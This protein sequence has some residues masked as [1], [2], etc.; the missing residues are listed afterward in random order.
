MANTVSVPD[1]NLEKLR[2]AIRCEY[3]EVA[4]APGKGFH[5]HTG[6]KLAEI[7]GY[8]DEWLA[9]IPE[10]AI[11][12]FAGTG[13][14][15]SIGRLRQGEKVLD[16]G[17]GA[18]I[19]SLI[20]ARQVGD[21]GAVVGIDMTTEM[22]DKAKRACK[23]MGLRHVEFRRGYLEDIPV[24]DAWADAVISNGT[25]NL[26]PD[27][28]KVFGEVYRVLKPGGRVQIADIM[29]AKPVPEDAKSDIALWTG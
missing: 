15:F 10:I 11:E 6:R 18:G 23:E 25:V 4:R 1:V 24:D 20:A 2:E 9:G 7:V 29:V 5:F 14:P 17:C 8:R 22:L 3:R 19:D 27:K 16:L 26:C 28:N 12:S 21:K 13:N